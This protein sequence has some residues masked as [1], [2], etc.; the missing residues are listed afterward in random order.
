MTAALKH[1]GRIFQKRAFAGWLSSGRIRQ[2]LHFSEEAARSKGIEPQQPQLLL[3]IKGL[4][5]DTR[6]TVTALSR[7][8]CLRHKQHGGTGQPARGGGC[9]ET[10]AWGAG[11]SR[12][13]G[14]THAAR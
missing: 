11:S 8:L 14:G 10:P 3:A 2:F 7:Q 1:S 5:K 12:S 13:A 4:P 9:F 6:P